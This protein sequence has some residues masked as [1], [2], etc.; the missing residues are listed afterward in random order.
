MTPL[1]ALALLAALTL[2]GTAL[3]APVIHNISATQAPQTFTNVTA[4]DSN[5]NGFTLLNNGTDSWRYTV[6]PVRVGETDGASFTA[7]RRFASANPPDTGWEWNYWLLIG[8]DLGAVN[9][10]M[11][12]Q[13]GFGGGAGGQPG[14]PNNGANG[15]VAALGSGTYQ[16]TAL[17]AFNQAPTHSF[18]LAPGEFARL[19]WRD[20]NFG[21]NTGG[22]SISIS[23][24][25][26]R[27]NQPVPE[28][29]SLALVG[30]A[31]AAIGAVRSSRR[32]AQA[33]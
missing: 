26:V 25:V 11:A 20:N 6:A 18:L 22:I 27:N 32:R 4:T 31:L 9:Y 12:Y 8:D 29:Q 15:G 21:D 24:E 28:P 14:S 33:A 2:T 3:A 17:L 10:A 19:Y 7:A 13:V 5:G 16:S 1:H 23:S 30:L